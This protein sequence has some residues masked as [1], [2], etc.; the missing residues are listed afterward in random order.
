MQK[1][2]DTRKRLFWAASVVV[3]AMAVY[4][5]LSPAPEGRDGA[6]SNE[7]SRLFRPLIMGV[8]RVGSG[9]S[10][11][12]R[13]YIH[14]TQTRFENDQ[15]H[16]EVAGLREQLL[17]LQ[18]AERENLRLRSLLSLSEFWDRKPIAARVI[19]VSTHHAI[20]TI[21]INRGW[22]D[23]VERDRPVMSQDGLTGGGL[24]GRVRVM[25]EHTS[26]VLL[27]TDPN[28]ALDVI[29]VRS[30]VRGLLVGALK[31]TALHRPVALAQ[32]EYVSQD[33]NIREGDV[34]ITSGMDGVYPKGLPVGSVHEVRKDAFGLFEEAWVLPAADLSRLEEVIV[35]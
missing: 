31:D 8:S 15:L 18:E 9:I 7:I 30:R 12:W 33:S 26:T 24:I 13:H 16:Q 10:S 23:G 22:A 14:L 34:L 21:T 17:A 35:R 11:I 32:L 6:I 27:I 5:V 3:I 29:D 25:A 20:R 2:R 4:S 1:V 19:A 28:S